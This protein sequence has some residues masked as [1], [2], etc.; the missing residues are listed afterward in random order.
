VR[1]EFAQEYV[2]PGSRVAVALAATG[3]PFAPAPLA[4]NFPPAANP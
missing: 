2:I 1:A 4:P 3:V